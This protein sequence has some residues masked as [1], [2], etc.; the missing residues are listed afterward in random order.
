M[1]VLGAAPL[2]AMA[3]NRHAGDWNAANSASQAIG[4]GFAA[5]KAADIADVKEQKDKELGIN[6]KNIDRLNRKDEKLAEYAQQDKLDTRRGNRQAVHDM[7]LESKKQEGD[8]RK[9]SLY[10]SKLGASLM[11]YRGDTGAQQA[12]AGILNVD[13]A[14][15]LIDDPKVVKNTQMLH[16]LAGELEKVATGASGTEEGRKALDAGTKLNKFIAMIK[17]QTGNEPTDAQADEF[18]K[19][20][21]TYLKDV[22]TSAHSFLYNRQKAI[23]D[24]DV[25]ITDPYRTKMEKQIKQMHHIKDES[26]PEATI[27]PP[28]NSYENM[29]IEELR[30]LKKQRGL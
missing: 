9:L 13:R 15:D 3:A 25:A 1:A 8:D 14:L 18:L 10:N 12:S 7:A 23:L 17:E 19:N 21:G 2:I 30:A 16:L 27:T 6:E 4:K 24:A 11:T 28:K 26:T 5:S 22:S 20:Y 29:S